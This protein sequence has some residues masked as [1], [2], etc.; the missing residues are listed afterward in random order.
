MSPEMIETILTGLGVGV[1]ALV[2]GVIRNAIKLARLE[3]RTDASDDRNDRIESKLDR[4][5]E[6]VG[7]WATK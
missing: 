5:I 3:A 2:G 1:V 4:L 7:K 6:M